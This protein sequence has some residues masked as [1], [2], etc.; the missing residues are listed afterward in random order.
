M[1]TYIYYIW[2]QEWLGCVVAVGIVSITDDEKYSISYEKT[3]RNSQVSSYNIWKY[4]QN[5]VC[6][7]DLIRNVK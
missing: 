6:R 3:Q 4:S 2:V 1:Y 7:F 5:Y